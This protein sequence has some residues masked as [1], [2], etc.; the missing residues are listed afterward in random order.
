MTKAAAGTLLK[1]RIFQVEINVHASW[2]LMAL[3]I[4]WSLASGAFPAIYGGLPVTGYWVMALIVVTGLAVS[5]VAHELAHTLVGRAFGMSVDRITLFLFGGVAEL[6]EEPKAPRA[7]L[8][9][10]LA[11]PGTSVILGVALGAAAGALERAGAPP[12]IT[13]ATAYL[14][15]LN[16]VLAAFNMLPAFPMDGG[17]VLRALIWMGTGRP[18]RATFV[19]ARIGLGFAI[20]LMVTG[21]AIALI[22]GVAGGLWWVLIGFFIYSA[23]QSSLSDMEAR[24]R[25]GGH[26]I[27][28]VMA[29]RIETAPAEMTL[30]AFVHQRLYASHHG[31]YPVMDGDRL[32]GVVEPNDILGTPRERWGQA[33]LG[34]VCRPL[35]EAA[36]ADPEDDAFAVLER[37]RRSGAVRMLILD[38]GRLAGM[39][40]LQDLLQRLALEMKFDPASERR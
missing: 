12:E 5:I 13:G 15:T 30:D 18:D 7:E 20:F 28:E 14:A 1:F 10:A 3:L 9:M 37:M 29:R 33:T 36:S 8:L 27:R 23:A 35:E 38:Q 25:L 21:V 16:L 26:A 31:M 39:V 34:Q 2:A 40:T 22:A 4:A 24:R 6:A 17:R 32:V 11:G 19:A